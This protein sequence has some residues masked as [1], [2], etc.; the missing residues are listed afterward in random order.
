MKIKII[1]IGKVKNS[2]LQEGINEFAKRL[3]R[4]CDLDFIIVKD[5]KPD[6]ELKDILDRL[7]KINNKHT[8]V[9][10]IFGKSFTSIEF[11][12]FIKRINKNPVFVIGS[13]TGLSDEIKNLA[14]LKLSLSRMTFPHEM[15]QLILLEQI[16]RAFSILKNTGYHK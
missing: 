14:D 16:Y 1:S 10:D 7:N 4:F 12:Q 3:R 9:L 2:Y 8:I 15:T 5:S 13:E 6:K 11:S